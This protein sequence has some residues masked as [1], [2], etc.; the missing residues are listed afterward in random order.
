M[1][2]SKILLQGGIKEPIVFQ[3]LYL[4]LRT[5]TMLAFFHSWRNLPSFR[6]SLEIFERGLQIEFL[7]SF[8][9][10]ILSILWPCALFESK[11]L[12]ILA[13]SLLKKFVKSRFMVVTGVDLQVRHCCYSIGSIDFQNWLNHFFLWSLRWFYFH[14][15]EEVC[16]ELFYGVEMFL[17]LTNMS[18][19]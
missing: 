15:N 9:I 19:D 11:W 14:E 10:W 2:R 18:S 7:H 16:K 4:F 17:I 8:V 6:K 5:C 1:R 12:I 13:M 3:T